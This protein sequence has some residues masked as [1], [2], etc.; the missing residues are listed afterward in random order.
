MKKLLFI[1]LL[2]CGLSFGQ[3]AMLTQNFTSAVAGTSINL[4]N[5]PVTVHRISW[6]PAGT[7]T[8]C[9]VALDSSADGISW[10]AGGVIAG[11]T[12]TSGGVA[13]FTVADVNFVRINVTTLTGG[14]NLNVAYTGYVVN[15]SGGGTGTAATQVQGTAATGAAAVGNP[16]Q[17]S[18]KD[19]N[20]NM[21]PIFVGTSGQVVMGLAT[22]AGDGST[23]GTEIWPSTGAGTGRLAVDLYQFNGTTW[24]RDFYCS[25]SIPI[26]TAAAATSQLIAL[27]SGKAIHVCGFT[28]VGAGATNV[29][30][31]YGT[32]ATCGT[33]TTVLTGA[34]PLAANT[35]V[36]VQANQEVFRA[37]AGNALCMINSAAIQVSGFLSYAQY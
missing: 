8:T 34:M 29:T 24:D 25:T 28:I 19:T 31:E 23:N 36:N 26:S 11:Q 5:S 14:G 21:Q 32:G 27:I 37:P 35:S 9:T 15:P 1:F 17:V 18:G 20:G 4:T 6:T 2:L 12:C 30:F 7:V 13:T 16:V 3:Q 10:N 22:S 33:G